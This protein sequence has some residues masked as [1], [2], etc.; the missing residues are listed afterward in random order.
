MAWSGGVKIWHLPLEWLLARH[1]YFADSW[2]PEICCHKTPAVTVPFIVIYQVV[3]PTI[4]VGI[5]RISGNELLLLLLLLL[6]KN[7]SEWRNHSYI[8]VTGA[9]YKHTQTRM[10][11]VG[12]RCWRRSDAHHNISVFECIYLKS[13]FRWVPVTLT[14]ITNPCTAYQVADFIISGYLQ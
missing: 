14:L 1:S 5:G 11:P 6:L 9:L 12:S 10:V 3:P 4:Y 8:T 13:H 2:D 7:W